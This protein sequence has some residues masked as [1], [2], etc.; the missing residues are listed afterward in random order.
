MAGGREP[1]KYVIRIIVDP[2]T[3][4]DTCAAERYGADTGAGPLPAP[5]PRPGPSEAPSAVYFYALQQ[6]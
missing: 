6:F 2:L 5:P 4:L 1:G 3:L